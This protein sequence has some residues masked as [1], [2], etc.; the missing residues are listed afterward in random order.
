MSDTIVVAPSGSRPV[1]APSTPETAEDEAAK[2]A[3]RALAR[4]RA[5]RLRTARRY[6]RAAQD[7]KFQITALKDAIYNEM[8]R[9]RRQNLGD[10]NLMLGQQFDQLREAADLRGAEFLNAA[11]DA[12]KATGDVQEAG[13]RNAVRERA[14][15]MTAILEQ[16]AGE[17]DAIRAMLMNA[18]NWHANAS[19]ASRTYFD[20]MQSINQGI[21][22]LNI[23]TKAALSNAHMQAEGQR[24][25]IWQDFYNRRAEALTS[26]GNLYGERASL[27]DQAQEQAT[28]LGKKKVGREAEASGLTDTSGRRRKA[29]RGARKYFAAASN[30]LGK[31]Y[32]QKPLPEWIDEYEG[33]AQVERRQENTNL[34]S[35]PVFEGVQKAEGATLRKWSA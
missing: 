12:E 35:A 26:L 14:D 11:S 1:V 28:D 17:T 22:D 33:T 3:S 19:E 24:E 30:E 10:I 7:L 18:R 15:S 4:D 29:R 34:A 5:A 9:S 16:G 27:L 23:D 31:S 21:T 6:S 8:A 13:I 25:A 2:A 32:E 20:T